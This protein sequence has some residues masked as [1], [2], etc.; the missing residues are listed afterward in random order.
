MPKRSRTTI[1]NS[2]TFVL[3]LANYVLGHHL[4]EGWVIRAEGAGR[5]SFDIPITTIGA[6]KLGPDHQGEI[7]AAAAIAGISGGVDILS[8]IPINVGGKIFSLN[9]DTG[10]SDMWIASDIC[11]ENACANSNVARYSKSQ[12]SLTTD[13]YID[14]KYGDSH[15]GTYASGTIGFD[16]VALHD[17]LN[18]ARQ[19]LG[20]IDDT[21]NLLVQYNAS[22]IIGLGFP[23]GSDIQETM[24][25]NKQ[26]GM[27]NDTGGFILSTP[28]NG[29]FVPRLAM[30]GLLQEPMFAISLDRDTTQIG[31]HGTLSL[32]KI[33]DG[34]DDGSLTWIPV[35]LYSA[36]DGGMPPPSFA[37]NQLYPFRWEIELDGV[38]LDGERLSDS[39][40][41]PRG[42]KQRKAS[43]LIDTGNSLLRGPEDVVAE[44]LH[45]VS[46]THSHDG[47]STP[48]PCNVPRTLA[49]E[50]GGKMFPVDPH[51]FVSQH[52]LTDANN[53]H[54][55]NIVPA[56]TPSHGSLFQWNL[57]TP[58]FRSNYVVFHYGNLTHPSVDPPRIGFKS[59]V[60]TNAG[61][62]LIN[63]V[64]EAKRRSHLDGTVSQDSCGREHSLT[65]SLYRCLA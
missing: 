7:G 15:S 2:F 8:T 47:S 65:K 49:F 28:S 54:L 27:I 23:A 45:K 59:K 25:L 32:G 3:T 18:L 11:H 4:S 43:A 41:L 10:S 40:I 37:P 35:R 9:L 50:I 19:P 21:T 53:C 61:E 48:V 39:A 13:L 5:R 30:H 14:M 63:A 56:D 20:L 52:D 36:E 42:V 57:G 24:E 46:P 31:G 12:S 44:I 22:G 38:F 26:S 51:D 17:G 6:S 16:M 62:I 34:V 64:E 29:P 1:Y 58:F 60:P 33:P 55:D